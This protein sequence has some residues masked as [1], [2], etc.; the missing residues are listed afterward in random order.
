MTRLTSSSACFLYFS[1][2]CT[3][4]LVLPSKKE[5][6]P[7]HGERNTLGCS[8]YN[9]KAPSDPDLL[10]GLPEHQLYQFLLVWY[11]TCNT[12]QVKETSIQRTSA[13]VP[14]RPLDRGAT[15]HVFTHVN[16][17]AMSQLSRNPATVPLCC[18][19]SVPMDDCKV[20]WSVG[21]VVLVSD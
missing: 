12:F 13:I 3:F 15:A 10:R 18:S 2:Y 4:Q 9:S 1:V 6:V 11:S 21:S 14:S 17:G 16:K 5:N 20:K 19:L 7:L 8:V